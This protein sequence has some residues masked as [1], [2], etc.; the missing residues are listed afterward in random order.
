MTTWH[1][2]S[3]TISKNGAFC[4]ERM[5]T[6]KIEFIRIKLSKITFDDL[7]KG[8]GNG[9]KQQKFKYSAA[10]SSYLVYNVKKE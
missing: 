10:I 8:E 6:R 7:L 4:E 3:A 1:E 5:K 9:Q 2:I